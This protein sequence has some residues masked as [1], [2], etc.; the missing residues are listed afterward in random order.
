MS[1]IKLKVKEDVDPIMHMGILLGMDLDSEKSKRGSELCS[2][3][4]SA[5]QKEGQLIPVDPKIIGVVTSIK[6]KKAL[7][8]YENNQSILKTSKEL[9]NLERWFSKICEPKPPRTICYYDEEIVAWQEREKK[10]K[11]TGISAYCDPDLEKEI[12]HSEEFIKSLV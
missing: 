9:T 5:N 1:R 6:F 2:S 12:K 8:T 4:Q 10:R 3:I 11:E 7:E